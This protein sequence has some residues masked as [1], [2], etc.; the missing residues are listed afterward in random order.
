MAYALDTFLNPIVIAIGLGVLA[1]VVRRPRTRRILQGLAVAVLLLCSNGWVAS[2]FVRTLEQRYVPPARGTTADAIIVL[3]GGER[4]ALWPR[5]S[6]E[7]TDGGD[8]LVYGLLLYRQGTAPKVVTT[9]AA[10]AADMASFLA[11]LGIPRG[12]LI[13][14]TDSYNTR[15]H[16]VNLCP[17]LRAEKIGK[18]LLVTSAI[19]MERAVG[20]F[21]AGCPE[22]DVIP[23]PTDYRR[24]HNPDDRWPQDALT[25]VPSPHALAA[26]TETLHEY[27][28]MVYYRLRGWI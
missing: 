2:A 22:L 15:D 25:L 26:V 19:H 23:A 9:G 1:R 28:G 14:D 10:V 7:L 4:R 3:S 6:L 8:R 21:A 17:R 27:V 20:V 12:A 11:D 16:A 13:T 24:P 18:V 5:P